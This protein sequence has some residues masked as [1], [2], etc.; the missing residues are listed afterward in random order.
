MPTSSCPPAFS[1]FYVHTEPLLRA[2]LADM[3]LVCC[4]RVFTVASFVCGDVNVFGTEIIYIWSWNN[5]VGIATG[6][7]L[8]DQGSEFESWWGQ[9]VQ[10]GSGVHPTFYP[11]G[12]GGS[13]RRDVKLTTHLHLV[14]R[15][16]KRGSIY[17]LSHTPSWRRA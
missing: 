1:V 3:K 13:F 2:L 12:T 7:G 14:P 11:T 10:T 16:R 6:Y 4:N 5:A 8:D 9:V 17:P 15:S